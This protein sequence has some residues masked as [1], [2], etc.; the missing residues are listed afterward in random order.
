MKDNIKKDILYYEKLHNEKFP[1]L[2]IKVINRI[3]KY[4]YF[5]TEFGICKKHIGNFD[6][7]SYSISSAINKTEFLIKRLKK[8]FGDKYDYSQVKFN[9]N[10]KEKIILICKVHGKFEKEINNVLV[11]K[12]SYC[13]LCYNETIRGANRISSIEDFIKKANLIHNNKYDYSKSIYI[14]A[15]ENIN[16]ICSKHDL[17][18]Q[19]PDNHLSGNGCVECAR[20]LTC[21]SYSNW[22]KA[23]SNSKEFDSF[24]VYILECWNENEKFYKIGK[25]YKTVEKRFNNKKSLPYNWKIL[26]TYKGKAKEM[27]ELE[28]KLKS[29]NKMN[30]YIPKIKFHGLS[31]CFINIIDYI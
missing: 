30:K 23:G 21:W 29:E 16:I 4:I 8:K 12:N 25:T 13:P 15:K 1:N 19:T 6:R 5:N 7:A 9:K 28:N 2:P 17:F 11:S 27:S 18:K 22:E 20:E 24:K 26:K 3:G 31:E 10:F 14:T